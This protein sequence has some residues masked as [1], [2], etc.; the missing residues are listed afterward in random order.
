MFKYSILLSMIL[1]LVISGCATKNMGKADNDQDG[2][3]NQMDICKNTPKLAIVDKYGCA[4]D[5]DHDGVID[6][7]D[8]CPNTPFLKVVNSNGCVK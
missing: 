8:K 3:I 4:V 1:T 2:V 7:Y 5:S 6:L